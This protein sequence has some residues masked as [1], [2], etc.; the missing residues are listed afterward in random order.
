MTELRSWLVITTRISFTDSDALHINLYIT[1][2]RTAAQ[3]GTLTLTNTWL[4]LELLCA[5]SRSFIQSLYATVSFLM[6]FCYNNT[7]NEPYTGVYSML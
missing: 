7:T 4:A 6:L 2:L 1:F 5:F 3:V